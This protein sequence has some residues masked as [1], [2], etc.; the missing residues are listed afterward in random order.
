MIIFEKNILEDM[1]KDNPE[2]LKLIY[3]LMNKVL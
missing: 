2:K 3:Q 1:P